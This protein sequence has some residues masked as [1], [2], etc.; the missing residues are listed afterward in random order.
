[1]TVKFNAPWHHLKHAWVGVSYRPEFYSTIKNSYIRDSLQT[2]AQETEE[3][4]LNLISV[5]HN[6]P[7]K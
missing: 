7:S 1:M 4:Y 5:H 2:I 3:D 6:F